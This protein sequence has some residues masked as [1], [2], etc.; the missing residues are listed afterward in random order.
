V[1]ALAVIDGEHYVPV[2]RDALAKLPYDFVAAFR[3]GGIEKLRNDEDYGVPLVAGLEEA[4][5]RYGPEVVVDLSD[6]PVLG[7]RERFQLA[8]QALA[9]GLPYVGADFRFDPP[10]FEPFELPSVAVFGTGKRVGKTA[11]TGHLARLLARDRDVLVVAMG[12]GG[13]PEPEVVDVPPT[14][15][16]LLARS[17]TGRHAASDHLETAALVG[18]STIGCRRA[19]GGLA[20]ATFDSNVQAGA[21]LAGERGADVVIFD[22]SGAAVPPVATGAR[23][24]VAHD[25]EHGLNPYRALI[26][27]LVLTMSEEV[28]TAAS[29]L[30]RRALRF[31][32]RLEPAESL[33]GRRAALF[34]TGPT[35]HDHLTE[36]ISASQNLADRDALRRDLD[37]A[38][39]EVFLVE[40]KAAAIDV[41]AEAAEERGI[42]L[43][44]ARN[45]V[46]ADGLDQA[47]LELAELAVDAKPRH[48]LST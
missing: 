44:L 39:A 41:V 30:G 47:L 2:V 31:D 28:A 20:G 4:L 38:D 45:D 11:V 37:A 15:A 13:P 5:A 9:A 7:P 43:V 29:A 17:R 25:L 40:L 26:S 33:A 3:A 46:V 27:D 12:R 8:S 34:T 1:R 42:E 6:E 32:L 14:V 48:N 21:R 23:V 36:I 10:T 24:L 35:R 19:G 22:G 16:D 18:V